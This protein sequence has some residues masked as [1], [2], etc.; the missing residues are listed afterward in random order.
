MKEKS[1]GKKGISTLEIVLALAIISV[2]VTSSV[3]ANLSG[4]NWILIGNKK[5]K[6]GEI[7]KNILEKIKNESKIYFY[8]S[9]TTKDLMC[10]EENDCYHIETKTKY[11]SSCVKNVEITN[12]NKTKNRATT[13]TKNIIELVNSEEMIKLGTDCNINEIKKSETNSIQEIKTLE[14]TPGK[15]YTGLDVLNKYI[16]ITS[17]SIPSFYIYKI[18]ENTE[19][20][21]NIMSTYDIKLNEISVTGNSLDVTKEISTGRIYA[22]VAIATTTNQLAVI[23]VTDPL[24][25]QTKNQI[26]LRNVPSSGSYPQGY[27]IFAYGNR[28]YVLTR[29]TAGYEL[30]IFNI[31]SPEFPTEIGS[32]FEI[33]RTIN[34]LYVRDQKI[35]N[36][37]KRLIFL[38]S[39]SNLKEFSILD[40][41]NDNVSEINSFNLPGNQ[42]GLS[43]SLSGNYVYFGRSNNTSG[44]ELYVFDIENP[45]D[46]QIVAQ[47]E[48]GSNINNIKLLGDFIF[49]TTSR[50]G[51]NFQIWG[52]DYKNWNSLIINS[53]RIDSYS[54]PNIP[55]LGIDLDSKWIYLINSGISTDKISI[56]EI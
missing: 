30:H 35:G 22:F 53:G 43:I 38:A 5:I 12:S 11:V 44:P 27:K 18:P 9:T 2:S 1:V 4:Q 32:G 24:N 8:N 29:E 3:S 31:E 17:N 54:F 26:T 6:A 16:Y 55:H 7:N 51:E 41:T 50:S 47:A 34:D 19:D 20:P 46:L 33:N 39:D 37:I 28:L 10:D 42:D 40:A 36:D 15:R 23:D 56:L 13:S 52:K 25:P 49:L 45:F 14:N 48:L 21:L